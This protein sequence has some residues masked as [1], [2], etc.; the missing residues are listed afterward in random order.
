MRAKRGKPE[1]LNLTK[2]ITNR[3]SFF[4]KI[5]LFR[6][7]K[8][9][10]DSVKD[11]AVMASSNLPQNIQ[12]NRI[13]FLKKYEEFTRGKITKEE[14]LRYTKPAFLILTCFTREQE[15]EI[16]NSIVD[17]ELD[18]KQDKPFTKNEHDIYRK[19]IDHIHKNRQE[20]IN[21]LLKKAAKAINNKNF[22]ISKRTID[23]ITNITDSDLEK[24]KEIYSYVFHGNSILKY[25]GIEKDFQEKKLT[26]DRTDD[27][28]YLGELFYNQNSVGGKAFNLKP[29]A[30]NIKGT[31]IW[32]S[33]ITDKM[34]TAELEGNLEKLKTIKLTIFSDGKYVLN[35]KNQP[36]KEGVN[37]VNIDCFVT[38]TDIGRELYFLLEDEILELPTNYIDSVVKNDNYKDFDLELLRL[39]RQ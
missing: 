8:D 1:K 30:I 39:P 31:L 13:S 38:L 26:Q 6:F 36:K 9:A 34:T 11:I 19:V 29:K 33:S 3:K 16:L 28:K 37:E 15:D 32:K 27:I 20:D 10:K 14:M 23:F 17:S 24:I 7:G 25:Q 18:I 22:Q 12:S 35:I 2:M 21:L 4:D 5:K